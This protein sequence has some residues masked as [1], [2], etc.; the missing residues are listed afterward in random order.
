[1]SRPRLVHVFCHQKNFLLIS[2]AVLS[3]I[4]VQSLVF[5]T[6]TRLLTALRTSRGALSDVL[7]MTQVSS[8]QK[9]SP[10]FTNITLRSGHSDLCLQIIS[11]SLREIVSTLIRRVQPNVYGMVHSYLRKSSPQGDCFKLWGVK[12]LCL[13]TCSLNIRMF[14]FAVSLRKL[15]KQVFKLIGRKTYSSPKN[16]A[17]FSLGC[18]ANNILNCLSVGNV[19]S[20]EACK[21]LLG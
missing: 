6:N 11:P 21:L 2:S 18:L 3:V 1:M 16:F 12:S 17:S 7:A 8:L 9:H 5:F 4:Q 10:I 20:Q 19:V 13:F 15:S 14:I